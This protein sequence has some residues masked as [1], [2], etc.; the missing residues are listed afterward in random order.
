MRQPS[1][2]SSRTMLAA[3]SEEGFFSS[4]A[5]YFTGVKLEEKFGLLRS[6]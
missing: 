2:A 1:A 6:K 5:G 3:K 4:Q